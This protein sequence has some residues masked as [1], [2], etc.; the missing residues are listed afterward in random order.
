VAAGPRLSGLFN[1]LELRC[2][3]ESRSSGKSITFPLLIRHNLSRPGTSASSVE[4]SRL[5]ES[6]PSSSLGVPSEMVV[7]AD[8][9]QAFPAP[10]TAPGKRCTAALCLH[11]SPKTMLTLPGALGRLISSFH[12]SGSWIVASRVGYSERNG[13]Q[14][15]VNGSPFAVHSSQFAVSGLLGVFE[16]RTANREP[17]TANSEPSGRRRTH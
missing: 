14:R 6:R 12:K 8:R 2:A 1:Q 7:S 13:C 11:P 3:R 10:L 9:E 15:S 5:A 17:R 16:R 4:S